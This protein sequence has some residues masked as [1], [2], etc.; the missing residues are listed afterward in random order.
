MGAPREMTTR[1]WFVVTVSLYSPRLY[2]GH[3][4]L[5]SLFK[6]CWAKLIKRSVLLQILYFSYVYVIKV[7]QLALKLSVAHEFLLQFPVSALYGTRQ[8][9][10]PHCM[11]H[12]TSV[13]GLYVT[14]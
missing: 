5:Y 9:Q 8:F 1:S 12:D 3:F 13:F 6:E 10:F 4:L 7:F 11:E 2:V 14:R